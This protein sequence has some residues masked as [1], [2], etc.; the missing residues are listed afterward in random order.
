MNET[1]K[2][3]QRQV[4]S[5][6]PQ[7]SDLFSSMPFPKQESRQSHTDKGQRRFGLPLAGMLEKIHQGII[8]RKVQAKKQAIAE[9]NNPQEQAADR[10]AK[11][12]VQGR[13]E[14]G[15]RNERANMEASQHRGS[16]VQ[17]KGLQSEGKVSRSFQGQLK[18]QKGGGESLEPQFAGKMGGLLGTNL[19]DV[20]IHTDSNADKLSRKVQAKAFTTGQDIYFQ[21]GEYQPKTESGKELIAHEVTHAAQQQKNSQAVGT[22]QRKVDMDWATYE[23]RYFKNRLDED[24]PSRRLWK[25]IKEHFAMKTTESNEALNYLDNDIK[26]DEVRQKFTSK[27]KEDEHKLWLFLLAEMESELQNG[28]WPKVNEGTIDAFLAEMFH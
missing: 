9:T 3:I 21:R 19:S 15:M 6:S 2:Q 16:V 12:A 4:E 17:K 23:N 24:N 10:V 27:A 26:E 28:Q 1:P 11:V 22:V 8:G 5:L 7:K 18:R 13:K 20:R 14:G 25:K